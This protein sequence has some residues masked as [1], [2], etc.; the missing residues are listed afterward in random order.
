MKFQGRSL[1]CHISVKLTQLGNRCRFRSGARRNLLV[2]RMKRRGAASSC[3][4]TWSRANY[5]ERTLDMRRALRAYPHAGVWCRAYLYR[6]AT[7]SH[8]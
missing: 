4:S 6:T 5:V 1:D 2:L 8:R 7:T 3:G